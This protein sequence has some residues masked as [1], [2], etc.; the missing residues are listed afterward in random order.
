MILCHLTDYFIVY[1]I[2]SIDALGFPR[3]LS[4]HVK[5]EILLFLLTHTYASM[6]FSYINVLWCWILPEIVDIFAC[7]L[8]LVKM[9]SICF[10]YIKYQ[11]Y[12][13]DIYICTC[14]YKCIFV[15]FICTHIYIYR[16]TYIIIFKK[17]PIIT[18]FLNFFSRKWLWILLKTFWFC[19]FVFVSIYED[20]C[21]SLFRL[22]YLN[23]IN[24]AAYK[25]QKFISNRVGSWKVQD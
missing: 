2:F 25:L 7:F 4:Y 21:L 14:L 23:T 11:F 9:P 24:W 5:V 13:K 22:L 20:T 17:C 18:I 12:D 15:Y 3:N 16:H 19:V 6:N 8:N 1:I 10:H